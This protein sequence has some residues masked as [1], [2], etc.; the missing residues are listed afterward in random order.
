MFGYSFLDQNAEKIQG[1][2]VNGLEPTFENIAG[3]KYNISRSLYFYIKLAHVGT[4]P[5]LQEFATEFT[6]ERAYGSDGYLVEKGLIPLPTGD[7]DKIRQN[8]K[9]LTKLSM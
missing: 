4:V 2:I 3:G 8:V 6:S 1:A 9:N 7:R 5:G